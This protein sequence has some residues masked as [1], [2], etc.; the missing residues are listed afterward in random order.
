MKK[1]KII[2]VA[3]APEEVKKDW[4]GTQK[5]IA[6]VVEEAIEDLE[7]EGFGGDVDNG[8]DQRRLQTFGT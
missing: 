3:E 1:E 6:R 5:F 4:S 8:D 2:A 7:E